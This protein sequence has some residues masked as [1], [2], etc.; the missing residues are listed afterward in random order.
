MKISCYDRP[1]G[2]IGIRNHVVVIPSVLCANEIAQRIAGPIEGVVALRHT[3]GCTCNEDVV[4]LEGVLAGLGAH[5]NV[6]G[7]LVL[8]LGCENCDS[9]KVAE[10]ISK[11]APWKPLEHRVIQQVGVSKVIDEGARI[12]EQMVQNAARFERSQTDVS[13]LWLALECGGSDATSGLAANPALGLAVDRFIGEGASAMFS[14]TT[15]AIGADHLLAERASSR[16]VADEIVQMVAAAKRQMTARLSPG[17]HFLTTGNMDGGLTTLEEKSLGCICKTGSTPITE[18][19]AYGQPPKNKGLVL[20][21]GTGFDVPSIT[22]MVAGGAQ[23]V[24]FTTG[25]G[26][27]VGYPIVPVIKITGNPQTAKRLGEIIDVDA[28]PIVGGEE[29]LHD[30]AQRIVDEIIAVASG[31]P[32]KAEQFGFVDFAISTVAGAFSGV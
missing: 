5:P 18:T 8:G 22:G 19:V 13:G 6:A 21:D 4:R 14:E 10:T 11:Q 9:T 26:T 20:V 32:T 17:E 31:K 28:S 29:D 15:E 7:V 25:K 3:G 23:I 16:Q 27:P 12:V 2:K 30:V 1:D 24:A